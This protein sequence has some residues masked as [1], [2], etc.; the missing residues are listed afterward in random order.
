MDDTRLESNLH[1]AVDYSECPGGGGQRC[2]C[3]ECEVCGQECYCDMDDMGGMDQPDDCP[4]FLKHD[5]ED[6]ENDGSDWED[7][8]GE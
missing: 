1:G 3:H 5:R 2:H 7:E 6:C 8:A 4:H